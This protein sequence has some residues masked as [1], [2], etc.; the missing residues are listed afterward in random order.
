MLSET[1]TMIDRY[2]IITKAYDRYVKTGITNNVTEALRLYLA[3]D[4]SP[5]EQVPLFIT[6]PEIQQVEKVLETIRPH[7]DE[8][9]A[10]MYMQID[11]QDLAGNRYPTAWWCRNCGLIEY[12]EMTHIEWLKELQ[13]EAG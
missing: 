2:K 9:D 11:A 12:S 6:S 3:N 8:C 1:I 5:D 7:C 13:S 10:E 4:A